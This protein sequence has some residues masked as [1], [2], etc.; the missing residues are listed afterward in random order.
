MKHT[1]HHFLHEFTLW[2]QLSTQWAGTE[3]CVR[4]WLINYRLLGNL[5]LGSKQ[6]L[7]R[8]LYEKKPKKPQAPAGMVGKNYRLPETVWLPVNGISWFYSKWQRWRSESKSS[9]SSF[10][11]ADVP[12]ALMQDSSCTDASSLPRMKAATTFY[13]LTWKTRERIRGLHKYSWKMW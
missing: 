12:A 2:P 4:A 1:S 9:T 11:V 6:W 13:F 5:L 7:H 3:A 8:W 10:D